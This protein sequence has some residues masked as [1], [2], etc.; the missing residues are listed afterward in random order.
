MTTAGELSP[1]AQAVYGELRSGG[2]VPISGLTDDSGP[3]VDLV[4][5]E[6]L[7]SG[8][9]EAPAT[10]EV[11]RLRVGSH[12]ALH[13]LLATQSVASVERSLLQA[14]QALDQVLS[15]VAPAAVVPAANPGLEHVSD[16]DVVRER[17]LQVVRGTQRELLNLHEGRAPTPEEAASGSSE[18]DDMLRRGVAFRTVCPQHFVQHE[19]IRAEVERTEQLG[20]TTRFA[21]SLP[22]RLIISDRRLAILPTDPPELAKGMV[23]VTE[24][25]L[26]RCL[27]Q[28][29]L[30]ILR[31]GRTLE[32]AIAL[33][34]DG[35]TERERE[36][37]LMMSSG[38]TDSVSAKR[39]SVTE[40]QF[41]R[42]VARVMER[43]GAT[44]RFQAG[45]LAVER[46]WL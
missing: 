38:L 13:G 30:T 9:V 40:R 41:R 14:R 22:H 11:L 34:D 2:E 12:S 25:A 39:L 26:V 3:D 1:R 28:L 44:S 16:L 18:D 19:Y 42:Y 17:L 29:A 43:L 7:G 24:P 10:G 23:F 8:L 36:V 31:S 33:P 45:V 46:G 35:P 6:L 20:A 37:L 15:A 4:V 27:T 5:K 32:E 21:D